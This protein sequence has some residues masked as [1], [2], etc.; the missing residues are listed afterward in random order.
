MARDRTCRGIGCDR[1]AR[2]CQIDHTIPYPD[3]PTAAGNTGPFCDRQHLFKTHGGWQVHQ[4][5]PGQFVWR[6]LTGHTYTK[7]P[8]PIGPIIDGADECTDGAGSDKTPHPEDPDPP[9]F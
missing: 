8:D 7:H 1:P 6:T 4:P 2:S 3:G 5:V 9:P